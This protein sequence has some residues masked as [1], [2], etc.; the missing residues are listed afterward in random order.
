MRRAP[1]SSKTTETPHTKYLTGTKDGEKEQCCILL[2]LEMKANSCI[3]PAKLLCKRLYTFVGRAEIRFLS[4]SWEDGELHKCSTTCWLKPT[5]SACLR[6]GVVALC[7]ADCAVLCCACGR[8]STTCFTWKRKSK[9]KQNEGSS[10]RTGIKRTKA[11]RHVFRLFLVSPSSLWCSLFCSPW[12]RI[13]FVLFFVS[14]LH[15]PRALLVSL[16][17]CVFPLRAVFSL[18]L[19]LIYFYFFFSSFPLSISIWTLFVSCCLFLVDIMLSPRFR[20]LLR[21]V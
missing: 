4:S 6:C 9:K 15:P 5:M 21:L 19:L 18:A 7:R 13:M 16:Q 8:F 10:Y 1:C 11:R 14:V 3:T 17:V 12:W 2:R 20:F